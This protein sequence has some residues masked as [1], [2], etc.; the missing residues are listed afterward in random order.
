MQG[1]PRD[2]PSLRTSLAT[3]PPE[4]AR[5]RTL[6]PSVATCTLSPLASGEEERAFPTARGPSTALLAH[7]PLPW[8]AN[9]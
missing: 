4:L 3:L 7:A 1:N 5:L 8:I 9:S 6:T 2:T